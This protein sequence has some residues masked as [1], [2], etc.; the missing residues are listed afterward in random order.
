MARPGGNGEWNRLRW[1][2]DSDKLVLTANCARRGWE[3]WDP[4][5]GDDWDVYWASVHSARFLFSPESNVKLADHQRVNHFPNQQELTRKDLMAK[6][7]RRHRKALEREGRDASALDFVPM[8]YTLPND[9]R[10]FAEEYKRCPNSTWIIKPSGRSQGKGIFL[11]NKLSQ[12]KRW[13]NSQSS[14]SSSSNGGLHSSSSAYSNG[15]GNAESFVVSRCASASCPTYSSAF[16]KH[17]KPSVYESRA[18][19]LKSLSSLVG[20][21][22]TFVSSCL[23][24]RTAH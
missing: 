9:L 16:D 14:S 23:S 3:M 22:S 7:L 2:S 10:L 24:P 21:S 5:D 17:S 1:R 19:T 8:T 13:V 11:V 12:V 18:G 6:N 20:A 4:E 15:S